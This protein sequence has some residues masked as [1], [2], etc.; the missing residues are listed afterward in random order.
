MVNVFCKF[1]RLRDLLAVV[2][3]LASAAAAQT[4]IPT[5]QTVEDVLHQM[6]DKA[7]VIFVGQVIAVH[8][9]EAALPLGPSR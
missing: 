9:I 8:P 5:P 2:M 1:Q 6:S 7:D 4:S 3:L